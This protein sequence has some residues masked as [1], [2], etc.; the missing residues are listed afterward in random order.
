MAIQNWSDDITVAELAD[1][2]QFTDEMETLTNGLA[3]RP[4]N[5]VLNFGPVSFLNSSNIAALLRLR[6][7]MLN[8]QK[9]LVLCG[10]NSQVGG[11]FQATGLD[12]IFEFT[13]DVATALATVQLS[14]EAKGKG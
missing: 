10:I 12:K 7:Q 1:D 11:V 3:D 2:P 5:V 8:S 6:R 4:A 13:N 14:G 9:Q